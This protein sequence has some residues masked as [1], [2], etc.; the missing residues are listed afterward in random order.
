MKVS[1]QQIADRLGVSKYSVSKALSGKPGVSMETRLQ[2]IE[3]AKAMGYRWKQKKASGGSEASGDPIAPNKRNKKPAHEAADSQPF[4]FVLID[5]SKLNEVYFWNRVLAG[6]ISGCNEIGWKH[7]MI[8]NSGEDTAFIFPAYADRSACAGIVVIGDVPASYLLSLKKLGIPIILTDHEEPLSGLDCVVNSNFEA[9]RELCKRIIAS[10]S[11]SIL[12]IG[13]D[14]HSVSFTQRWWGC[15]NAVFE[16]NQAAKKQL[17]LRKWN[18]P[19]KYERWLPVLEEKIA[20][21][22]QEMLPDAIVCANDEIA[23][24]LLN[25]LQKYQFAVPRDCKVVGFDNTDKAAHSIPP[26]T[27]VDLGKEML[28]YRAIE[29]LQRRI[30][31]PGTPTEKILLAYRLVERESG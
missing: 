23:F 3:A 6:I 31:K 22:Q 16:E 30:L 24:D 4:I 5:A 2:V 29:A 11:R 26:L 8:T 15:Q 27:T 1:M 25:L 12:F 14:H 18:L 10:G 9:A 7:L 19:S 13:S 28:G 20:G 17:A 21:L